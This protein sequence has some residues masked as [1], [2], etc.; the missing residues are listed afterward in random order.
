MSAEYDAVLM[1]LCSEEHTYEQLLDAVLEAAKEVGPGG[2]VYVHGRAACTE[3]ECVCGQMV[4]IG[5][6]PDPS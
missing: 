2:F 1:P 5:P 3:D 4:T 6:M